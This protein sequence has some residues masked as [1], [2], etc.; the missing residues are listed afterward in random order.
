ML[1]ERRVGL[2]Y[3][4]VLFVSVYQGQANFYDVAAYLGIHGYRFFDFYNFAYAENGQLKWGDAIFLP[5]E[6]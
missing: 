4:E 6:K 3:T 5:S 1:S 2:V